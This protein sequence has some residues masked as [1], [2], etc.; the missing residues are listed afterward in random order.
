MS[1]FFY[2]RGLNTPNNLSDLDVFSQNNNLDKSIFLLLSEFR[3]CVIS[4]DD[5]L[6]EDLANEYLK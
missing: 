1:N 3:K 4:S 6:S 2:T 5:S